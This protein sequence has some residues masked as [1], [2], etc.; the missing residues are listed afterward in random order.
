MKSTIFLL[1]FS[2]FFSQQN[3]FALTCGNKWVETGDRKVE[4]L[5]KCGEPLLV[6]KYHER[7]IIYRDFLGRVI[8]GRDA[9][10]YVEE[11]TY[12]FGSN[13]F[14]SFLKFVNDRL[15]NIEEGK[16]GFDGPLPSR[17][18]AACGQTVEQGD[19]KIDVLM[20]CGPPTLK[21]EKVEEQYHSIFSEQ[22]RLFEEQN[23]YRYIEEWTYNF[24]PNYFLYFIKLENGRV[25]RIESGGYGY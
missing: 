25:R 15:F 24:G 6:E 3:S 5:M 21:D 14:L 20:K 16:R 11:W 10:T 8:K 1:F 18:K 22:D 9:H 19:R 4:V 7:D 13:R 23:S 12:N 2:L 17:P